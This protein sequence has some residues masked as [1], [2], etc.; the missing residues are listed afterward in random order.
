MGG[1]T[2]CARVTVKL[3]QAIRLR[4][5]TRLPLRFLASI[6]PSDRQSKGI[7]QSSARSS[8]PRR[9]SSLTDGC[10]GDEQ[11][12]PQGNADWSASS[13]LRDRGCFVAPITWSISLCGTGW[14]RFS[15]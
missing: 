1:D 11:R 9:D 7:L 4:E 2:V 14:L 6:G 12:W 15:M 13:H 5:E 3:A 8:V 10:S